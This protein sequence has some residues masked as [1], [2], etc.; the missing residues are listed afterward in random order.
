[1]LRS[2]FSRL[3]TR[4]QAVEQIPD[5][6]ASFEFIKLK[7]VKSKEERMNVYR[8][9]R[10]KKESKEEP[11]EAQ[12]STVTIE[13]NNLA[14]GIRTEDGMDTGV[15]T[16]GGG[17]HS[18]SDELAASASVT[19]EAEDASGESSVET[20]AEECKEE[21]GGDTAQ[22][23][24]GSQTRRQKK[25]AKLKEQKAS[26][27]SRP[28]RRAVA[29]NKAE[30]AKAATAI[31]AAETVAVSEAIGNKDV[32]SAS[33]VETNNEAEVE[34]VCV[35]VKGDRAKKGRQKRTR[36]PSGPI[37]AVMYYYHVL[38]SKLNP[39]RSKS[40]Y[41]AF[42]N[43]AINDE[44]TMFRSGFPRQVKNLS[45]VQYKPHYK[46]PAKLT[47]DSNPYNPLEGAASLSAQSLLRTPA[48]LLPSPPSLQNQ[49]G[50]YTP[51]SGT[52]W[53]G[54]K[55]YGRG[56][57][58]LNAN[59]MSS[60]MNQPLI[61]SHKFD[62]N[63]PSP[64]K[65]RPKSYR[66]SKW[67]NFLSN[68]R[69]DTIP[70]GKWK[71]HMTL[72]NQLAG[73]FFNCEPARYGYDERN[74]PKW[75]NTKTCCRCHLSFLV[76][77]NGNHQSLNKCV[78]HLPFVN[79][80]AYH[81][82]GNK[83]GKLLYECC[84]T[85]INGP[86]CKR[87]PTHVFQTDLEIQVFLVPSGFASATTYTKSGTRGTEGNII[88]IDC[89]M[90][91]TVAGLQLAQVVAV[92]VKGYVKY[93]AYVIPDD[94]IL[95]YNTEHSGVTQQHL[96]G[97][98]VKSLVQVR[99]DLF[100]FITDRT[101]IVGHAVHNDF[102]VLKLLHN[103]VVD[104]SLLYEETG[105]RKLKDLAKFHLNMDIHNSYHEGHDCEEDARVTMMLALKY[106]ADRV[107]Q[108]TKENVCQ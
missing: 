102:R 9:K 3:L 68:N 59:A 85:T 40:M 63:R 60:Q 38:Q 78:Y 103:L 24:N 22:V 46:S 14:R 66:G 31:V 34:D 72:H 83:S 106:I 44:D 55:V 58:D 95:S 33:E 10:I 39:N 7:V 20:T 93:R 92:D 53:N 105:I 8:M 80:C 41:A 25:N 81:P 35:K 36:T 1:M 107:Q 11:Q 29:S 30:A 15:S 69:N 90:V 54:V 96:E 43:C 32:V 57:R 62:P 6:D 75:N 48:S 5:P 94:I 18:Q 71:T 37:G 2:V 70:L 64:K 50:A 65:L 27:N 100:Q 21:V 17:G 13:E 99:H 84:G 88:S 98:G 67:H 79:E 101:I 42:L 49:M 23:C 61:T 87:E 108:G 52:D 74:I 45:V 89:E 12:P 4:Q 86:E 51:S 19:I 28:K 47:R 104:T 16:A 77:K 76:F 82:D 73:E 91:Y 56:K 26:G 97:P